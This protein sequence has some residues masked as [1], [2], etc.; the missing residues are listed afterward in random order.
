MSNDIFFP[1]TRRRLLLILFLFYSTGPG[2]KCCHNFSNQPFWKV[3]LTGS[4]FHPTQCNC[5]LTTSVAQQN[6]FLAFPMLA[7]SLKKQNKNKTPVK[8]EPSFSK[9]LGGP[10]SLVPQ[11]SKK[12]TGCALTLFAF[13]QVWLCLWSFPL[14]SFPLKSPYYMKQMKYRKHSRHTVSEL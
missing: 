9:F 14:L 7:A 8:S 2:L 5:C 4:K 11:V 10:S 12:N 6:N 3:V 1:C 13:F